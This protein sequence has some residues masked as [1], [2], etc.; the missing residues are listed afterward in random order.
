M[1]PTRYLERLDLVG[2]SVLY[3][4]SIVVHTKH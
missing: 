2:V 1:D 4:N 3:N